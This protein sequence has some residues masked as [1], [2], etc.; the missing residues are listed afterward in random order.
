MPERLQAIEIPE[1][2]AG[3]DCVRIDWIGEV[4]EQLNKRDRAA[5]LVELLV[6]ILEN[7]AS[8]S[9]RDHI[10]QRKIEI[11]VDALPSLWIGSLWYRGRRLSRFGYPN[12]S[13]TTVHFTV[14]PE[15]WISLDGSR[16]EDGRFD[17]PIPQSQIPLVRKLPS[18]E[19]SGLWSRIK[20]SQL[21]CIRANSERPNVL[22]PAIELARFYC[23]HSSV[24]AREL[25]AG[26]WPKL[27]HEPQS[28]PDVVDGRARIGV[29]NMRQVDKRSALV[30][31]RY[32]FSPEMRR[33]VDR[34]GQYLSYASGRPTA[35]F[36]FG[37]PHERIGHRARLDC[38]LV[39][40]RKMEE[41]RKWET[42]YLVTRIKR[43]H[44]PMPFE[45][46]E[47]V[48]KYDPTAGQVQDPSLLKPMSIPKGPR[49]PTDGSAPDANGPR[50]TPTDP[51]ST[52]ISPGLPNAISDV[53]PFVDDQDRFAAFDSSRIR[54]VST[55]TEQKFRYV[56]TD[57][58][59]ASGEAD[60]ISTNPGVGKLGTL[61]EAQ[62]RTSSAESVP[63]EPVTLKL[64]QD[65]LILLRNRSEFA[66]EIDNVSTQLPKSVPQLQY[67][68]VYVIPIRKL[69]AKPGKWHRTDPDDEIKVPI[70]SRFLLMAHVTF[71]NG[72]EFLIAEIE[73]LR[74]GEAYSVFCARLPYAMS[75]PLGALVLRIATETA[76]RNRWPSWDRE[77]LVYRIGE[78]ALSGQPFAHSK[79][80]S[81]PLEY[82]RC[83][84]RHCIDSMP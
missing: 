7:S 78:T 45:D 5:F 10:P 1:L 34:T 47:V 80:R 52:S 79:E 64:L 13:A 54:L 24:L 70:R 66:A 9:V 63:S 40:F 11:S 27:E 82:A 69:A 49:L 3:D 72:T 23:C 60:G 31:A 38:E 73:R 76:N 83:I 20:N 41:D 43:C 75:E 74:K 39:E 28:S 35:R 2:N 84:V 68:A 33:Q 56:P 55:K 16:T 32:K 21:L 61:S 59:V 26:G 50:A 4:R 46:L 67:G 8:G 44:E 14:D 25:F 30:L 81:G 12:M 15:L 53:V 19:P 17:R 18:G 42:Y 48:F 57:A 51:V 77:A 37:L 65:A 22:I 58:P 36:R 29:D 62:I 6:S 71:R